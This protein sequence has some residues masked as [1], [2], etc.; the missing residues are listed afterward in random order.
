MGR[1]WAVEPLERC[2]TQSSMRFMVSVV[3][4]LVLVLR[5]LVGTAMAVEA[6]PCQ[7]VQAQHSGIDSPLPTMALPASQASACDEPMVSVG[8]A[9][10]D[11]TDACSPLGYGPACLPVVRHRSFGPVGACCAAVVAACARQRHLAAPRRRLVCQRACGAR[12]QT[13]HCLTLMPSRA[14]A[15]L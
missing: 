13:A 7:S 2:C 4:M 15:A 5:G 9:C 1:L 11:A 12:L 3:V 14:C 10:E 8:S 6:T